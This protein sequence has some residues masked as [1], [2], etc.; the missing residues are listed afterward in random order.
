[1]AIPVIALPIN[2]VAL[3]L[4]RPSIDQSRCFLPRTPA[5]NQPSGPVVP[6]ASKIKLAVATA[7]ALSR[8]WAFGPSRQSSPAN[9][10]RTITL[11]TLSLN[12]CSQPHPVS[13][14]RQKPSSKPWSFANWPCHAN[15]RVHLHAFQVHT[16]P[17]VSPHL[18][19]IRPCSSSRGLLPT[20]QTIVVSIGGL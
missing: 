4:T 5:S 3:L 19:I 6:L 17:L 8:S 16:G 7:T 15:T 11:Q 14:H 18:L 20:R 10:P 13:S 12:S 9:L 1:M 2:T